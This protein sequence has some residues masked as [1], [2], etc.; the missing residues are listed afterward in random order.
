MDQSKTLNNIVHFYVVYLL[1]SSSISV[2]FLFQLRK[3]MKNTLFVDKK[4]VDMINVCNFLFRGL[5]V[6]ILLQL[7]FLFIMMI[8]RLSIITKSLFFVMCNVLLCVVGFIV[9]YY[10]KQLRELGITK[11]INMID[12]YLILGMCGVGFLVVFLIVFFIL[13]LKRNEQECLT[14]KKKNYFEDL[15]KVLD[16]FENSILNTKQFQELKT[17]ISQVHKNCPSDFRDQINQCFL[18]Y[19]GN[20][21]IKDEN[22]KIFENMD[23]DVT[24]HEKTLLNILDYFQFFTESTELNQFNRFIKQYVYFLKFLEQRE[25]FY[26]KMLPLISKHINQDINRRIKENKEE[27][28]IKFSEVLR[29]LGDFSSLKEIKYEYLKN[30]ISDFLNNKIYDSE[31]NPYI[32]QPYITNIKEFINS[33]IKNFLHECDTAKLNEILKDKTVLQVFIFLLM[34]TDTDTETNIEFLKKLYTGFSSA[35]KG[36]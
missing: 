23:N 6:L 33:E 16:E 11:S 4:I 13:S 29:K 12:Q 1:T 27:F 36:S 20:D 22:N 30:F 28:F 10:E 21:T 9:F 18:K 8:F 7:F 31:K 35:E 2:Y 14:L 26:I 3:K 25:K 24:D 5:L 34:Y 19:I 17:G 32:K 15:N